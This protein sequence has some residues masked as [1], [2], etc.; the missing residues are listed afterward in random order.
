MLDERVVEGRAQQRPSRRGRLAELAPSRAVSERLAALPLLL[1][2]AT[3]FI[4]TALFTRSVHDFSVMPDE[5]G[6]AK[7][8]IEIWNSGSLVGSHDIYFNSWAQ[9]L[10]LIS[11]PIFGGLG[12]VQ[13][14]HTAHTVYALLLASTAIPA[15]L[16]A[17]ELR[18]GRLAAYLVAALTVAVPW[19]VLASLVMTEV[20]AYPTFVWAILAMVRTLHAPSGRRDALAIT[21]IAVAF[22]ARTQLVILGPILVVAVFLLDVVP[23][24]AASRGRGVRAAL[25]SAL[26]RT[27][28]AHSVLWVVCALVVI[29]AIGLAITGSVEDVLGS[30]VTPVNGP[31][32]PPGTLTAGFNELDPITL[33]I[34]VVPLTL[35]VTWAL[36][37]AARPRD[38]ARHA[39]A[40]LLVLCLPAFLWLVGSFDARFLGGNRT[41]RYMFYLAPLLLTGAVA[42]VVDRRGSLISVSIVGALVAWMVVTVDL[43]VSSAPTILNPSFAVHLAFVD[44][45]SRLTKALGLPQIDP[46]VLIAV[47]TSAFTLLA[48]FLRRRLPAW[49]ALLAVILPVLIYGLA[50]TDYT[51]VKLSQ[52]Y[53]RTP[54]SRPESQ[55]WIDHLVPASATVGLLISPNGDVIGSPAPVATWTTWWELGFWNKSV[56]R[57]FVFPGDDPFSQGFVTFLNQ[58]LVH[59]RLTGLEGANY[60][61]KLASDPRFVPRGRILTRSTSLDDVLG[62]ELPPLILYKLDPGAPLLYGTSGVDQYSRLEPGSHPFLRVFGS[63]GAAASERV[64][65]TLQTSAAQAACPCRIRLGSTYGD[66]VLPAASLTPGRAAPISRIVSVPPRGYAQLNLAVTG[67]DGQPVPWVTLLSVRVKSA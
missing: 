12:M 35:A 48:V 67:R 59:G 44:D 15:Y 19:M 64:T 33:A 32:V 56:R 41:D 49:Q 21:A 2:V 25:I 20:V 17:R 8:S 45:G 26:R 42:W 27:L 62:Q 66:A 54:A 3:A 4:V 30:Y 11:A 24:V 43:E 16:L 57:D 1:I 22:F 37:T 39:F 38:P 36:A 28:R 60:L 7:Q 50:N 10:P 31:L 23:A 6:Y 53:S 40:V 55:A 13:A 63:G 46:R 29:A 58:D 52:V 5:L 65:V 14:Y 51:M 61:V 18:L 9:L 34:G 47:I